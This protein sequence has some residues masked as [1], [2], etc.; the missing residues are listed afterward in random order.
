VRWL[1][2]HD[3]TALTTARLVR[4]SRTVCSS[5]GY[6][7]RPDAERRNVAVA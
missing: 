6:P 3:G 2:R 7:K 1:P 5:S 4:S